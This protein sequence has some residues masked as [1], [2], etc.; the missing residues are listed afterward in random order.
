M[1]KFFNNPKSHPLELTLDGKIVIGTFE[2]EQKEL[3]SF[4]LSSKFKERFNKLISTHGTKL[5]SLKDAAIQQQNG[6]I[7][8][9]DHRTPDGIMGNVPP[10][11]IIGAFEVQSGSLVQNSYQANDKYQFYTKFGKPDLPPELLEMLKA[12]Y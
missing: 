8:L 2:D 4:R 1:I 6:Y 3:S 5:D 11:D 7:Y 12:K 10:E 9:I